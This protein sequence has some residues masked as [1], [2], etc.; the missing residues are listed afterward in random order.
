MKKITLILITIFCININSQAAECRKDTVLSYSFE[1]VRLAKKVFQRQIFTYNSDNKQTEELKQAWDTATK[2]W[3]NASKTNISYSAN[4]DQTEL[5]TQNWNTTASAWIN[6]SRIHNSYDANKNKTLDVRQNWDATANAWVNTSKFTGAFNANNERT[7]FLSQSWS[8]VDNVWVNGQKNVWSFNGSGIRT[9][10]IVYLWKTATNEWGTY[11]KYTE[12]I[13]VHNFIIR[14]IRED[15][16][17]SANAWVFATDY[18]YT[19]DSFKNTTDILGYI[20]N[21]PTNEWLNYYKSKSIINTYNNKTEELNQF[22]NGGDWRNSSK[23]TF[24]YSS[25]NFLIA[26]ESLSS[27]NNIEKYFNTHTRQEIVCKMISLNVNKIAKSNSIEIY[28][29]PSNGFFAIKSQ[30]NIDEVTVYNTFGAMVFTAKPTENNVQ[31]N[32]ETKGIHFVVIKSNG[33]VFNEKV[34]VQ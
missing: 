26:S 12:T 23:S 8:V 5:L 9:G 34:I 10:F 29:N 7:E 1:P 21:S 28:P 4:K 13:G 33:Q 27:W 19:Y 17:A 22:W 30:T 3:I 15:W 32:L 11:A 14:S 16:N 18:Y 25:S 31:L 6:Q 24:E 2:L 20:W